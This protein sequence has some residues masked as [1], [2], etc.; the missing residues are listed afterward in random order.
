MASIPFTAT[1]AAGGIVQNAL[2][3][4][5]FEFLSLPS[6]VQVYVTQDAVAA[7][8]VGQGTI[9]VFF[10]AELQVQTGDVR[11]ARGG[12][13][14]GPLVPDDLVADDFAAPR[15]RIV[16]RL[17][18]SGGADPVTVRGLVKVDVVAA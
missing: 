6:R 1:V 11:E 4:S 16:V 10:G 8:T 13:G 17:A 15:D 18:E 9:E 14:T 7:G 12:A 2:A 5:Q 3:G